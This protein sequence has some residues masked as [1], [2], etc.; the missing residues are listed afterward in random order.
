MRSSLASS[1]AAAF[2]S[3][4]PSQVWCP[5]HWRSAMRPSV[6]PYLN[7]RC[8]ALI[9]ARSSC[10]P[11]PLGPEACPT[12]NP[13]NSSRAFCVALCIL[14]PFLESC[15]DFGRT[16]TRQ[17]ALILKNVV[18]V[19]RVVI[20]YILQR[21]V[22]PF[23]LIITVA[24]AAYALSVES[25]ITLAANHDA[26]NSTSRVWSASLTLLVEFFATRSKSI[27]PSVP[28]SDFHTCA[29]KEASS[30]RIP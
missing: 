29:R 7:N 16:S 13:T 22:N 30:P 10:E 21:R 1:C 25:F 19:A 26:S 12:I 27:A 4:C 9:L 28:V 20:V 17:P 11:I 5:L 15:P 24:V 8:A 18:F 14:P 23:L 6:A 3:H 2:S